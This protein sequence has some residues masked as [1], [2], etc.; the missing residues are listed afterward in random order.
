MTDKPVVVIMGAGP[1]DPPPGI[2]RITDIVEIRYAPD[3][4]SLIHEIAQAEVLYSWW[5]SRDELEDAWA[6]AHALRWVQV[7][8]VG[9]HGFLFP[10]LIES[11]VIVT[12][13][14]GA[15]ERHIAEA[16][17]G[18]LVAMARGFPA[19]FADQRAHTWGDRDTERLAGKRL[20]IVGPGPIGREIASA[21]KLG[22]HMSV[23]AVGRS[24]RAG[25][26]VF[27]TVHGPEEFHLALAAADYVVD[28][29]PLTDETLHIFDAAAFASMKR[30]AR[31]VN[32]GRGATVDEA[33]LVSALE[34]GTL[35]GAALDVFENEPLPADSA[36]WDMPGVIVSPH[37]S[38]R[39]QGWREDFAS[40]F[41][42][43]VERWVAGEELLNI[44]DKQLGFPPAH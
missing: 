21:C 4:A 40:I 35:G 43:N 30:G 3:L 2:S 1:D 22:L 44:V 39:V 16:V 13:G 24:E 32:I 36:L 34:E 5:G 28:A 10:A 17:L 27:E 37:T 29:M 20:L 18:Y 41:Y 19:I 6:F 31:F 8:N 33:A 42:E 7:S 11:E 9:V 38:G 14:R 26:E 23:D 12:N 25:D 15:A